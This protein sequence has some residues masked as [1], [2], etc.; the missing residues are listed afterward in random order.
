MSDR[1][2]TPQVACHITGTTPATHDLIRD[3]LHRAPMYSGQIEGTGPRYCPSIEDKVVRFAERGRHQIFL[4]PEGLDDP[5]VYPNGISTSLPKEVQMA[6]L[7]TIPGL[8]TAVMAR[9][10][11][12]IEYDYVD[13]RELEPTLETRRVPG[14]FLAGQINGTTGYEEAAAQGLLAGVNAALRAA[15]TGTFVLDRADAYMG[16]LIDDL[17]TR[18]TTE[19][20]RMFTSRAEYR[21]LLRS[22]NADQR[23][24]PRGIEVGC[25]SGERGEAFTTKVEGL[26]HG[27]AAL[28]DC[29]AS[30]NELR[31]QGITVAMDGSRRSAW[32]VLTYPG[33]TVGM[34]AG[35]WPQLASIPAAVAA[36]LEIE[37]S[38]SAYLQR[39]AADIAAFRRDESLELPT[40]MDLG[41]IDGLSAEVRTKLAGARPATLGAASRIPGITPAALTLLLGHVRRRGARI[42][43]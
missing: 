17:V 36:Q 37:A 18:G 31:R 21:L 24:T 20:Y 1:I 38:Y 42:G 14:L 43:P 2:R 6:M 7:Q 27:R 19:P 28:D 40:D 39:Q 15:G 25:V 11:Y 29:A 5:T 23:L 3:N 13:P 32:D 12:A 41:A 10:G 26:E 16:V 35:V 9:P 33:V 4:E 30:P 34:L 22:D 8:E